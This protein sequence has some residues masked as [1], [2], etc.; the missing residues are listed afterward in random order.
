MR[1]IDAVRKVCP[2]ARP[3]Y[4]AAIENGDGLFLKDGIITPKRLAQFLAQ[5]AAETGGFTIDWESGN[6]TAQRIVEV[7]GPGKHSA[8]IGYAEAQMLAHNGQAL[9]ERTYGLGNPKKARELGNTQPG[10]GWRYRGG[11]IMQTTG[12]ANYRRMGQK[13]GVDFEGM[14]ELVL[15]A[16]H[17]LKPALAEWSEGHLNDFADKGDVLSISRKIN[18]GNTATTAIPNGYAD[19]KAWLAKFEAV[20]TSVE[21]Q[22]SQAATKVQVA[23]A[24]APQ[25][26]PAAV[27]PKPSSPPPPVPAP[28]PAPAGAISGLGA[29]LATLFKAIFKPKG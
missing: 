21:L 16:E 27:A 4:L 29:I 19:R 14:P 12:R 28:S 1:P 2:H 24:P 17:A 7:F 25:P 22:A 26:A 6:Y 18:I 9:F 8:A 23:P 20:I 11:G 15:S 3:S 13:C 10:D 5:G